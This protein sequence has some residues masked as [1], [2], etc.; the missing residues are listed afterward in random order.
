MEDVIFIQSYLETFDLADVAVL[1]VVDPSDHF[2]TAIQGYAMP[3]TVVYDR[4]G[5]LVLH[6][7]G[8]FVESELRVLI[9]SLIIKE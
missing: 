3:E 8:T 6:A 1:V 5:K 7:R 9:E 2:Y 4:D